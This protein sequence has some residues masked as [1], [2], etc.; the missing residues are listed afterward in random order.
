METPGSPWE[1][2]FGGGQEAAAFE[3]GGVLLREPAATT[4]DSDACGLSWRATKYR[5]LDSSHA[6]PCSRCVVEHRTA[7]GGDLVGVCCRHSPPLLHPSTLTP[8]LST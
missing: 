6:S 2:L 7:R 3:E 1:L 4:G 8:P 5:C